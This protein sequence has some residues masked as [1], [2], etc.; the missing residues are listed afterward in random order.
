MS[1]LTAGRVEE[2]LMARRAEGHSQRLS[3]N[4]M[5]PLLAYLRGLGVLPFPP[6]KALTPVEVLVEEYRRYLESE[7][8]LAPKSVKRYLGVSR[9][10]L[11][12]RPQVEGLGLGALAASEVTVFVVA[13]CRRRGR[14]QVGGD[15]AA[16]AA[17][18]LVLGRPHL[19]KAAA[20]AVAGWVGPAVSCRSV[21]PTQWSRRC[22]PAA[23][24]PPGGSVTWPS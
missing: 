12:Q 10:F 17:A 4:A 22:W 21:C 7:R 1:D 11:S 3:E 16:L 19:P 18:V 2:F 24:I 15:C 6:P 13:E 9:L 8:G 23:T 20:V 14:G 5:M